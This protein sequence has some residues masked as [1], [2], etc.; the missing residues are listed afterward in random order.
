MIKLLFI[1]DLREISLEVYFILILFAF[2]TF[3]VWKRF[4]S[5]LIQKKKIRTLATWIATLIIT[6]L[7]YIIIIYLGLFAIFYYPKHDFDSEKWFAEKETRYELSENIIE[8]G[9]LIGKTKAEVRLLLGD[10]ENHDNNDQWRYYLG[11]IPS[12]AN[13][14]P[15]VLLIEFKDGKVIRVSQYNS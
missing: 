5:K 10:E 3:Y 2:P 4:L 12:I 1:T 8:S 9:M 11:Y 14:D 13:I 15:D 6:P 7:M